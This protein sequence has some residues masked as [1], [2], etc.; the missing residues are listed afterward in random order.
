VVTN[1]ENQIIA[2]NKSLTAQMEQMEQLQREKG[3]LQEQVKSN[4][5]LQIQDDGT[6]SE[7]DKKIDQLTKEKEET[8]QYLKNAAK[9]RTLLPMIDCV[10]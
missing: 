6:K 3:R 7:A 8:K 2:S 10:C 1:K 4:Q 9:V 5:D